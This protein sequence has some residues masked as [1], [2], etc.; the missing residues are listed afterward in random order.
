MTG[1]VLSP[2]HRVDNSL[3]SIGSNFLMSPTGMQNFEFD[4]GM[5]QQNHQNHQGQHINHQY[6][7]EINSN[8]DNSRGGRLNQINNAIFDLER[9]IADLNRNYKNLMIKLNVRKLI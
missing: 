7:Y 4:K 6:N 3:N 8:Q 1:R 9:N 2:V 5:N